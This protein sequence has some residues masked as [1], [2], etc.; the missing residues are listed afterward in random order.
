MTTLVTAGRDILG[1]VQDVACWMYTATVA[2]Q[3]AQAGGDF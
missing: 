2:T 1:V 3:A